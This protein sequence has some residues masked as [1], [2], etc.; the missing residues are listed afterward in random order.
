MKLFGNDQ[1]RLL[2]S[3]AVNDNINK[4][5][6]LNI[7]IQEKT[8]QTLNNVQ[9]LEENEH[10]LTDSQC[11]SHSVIFFI[12]LLLMVPIHVLVKTVQFAGWVR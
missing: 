7:S 11:R 1:R 3:Q 9:I 10:C 4:Q 2:L 12:K 5:I 6:I 8:Y